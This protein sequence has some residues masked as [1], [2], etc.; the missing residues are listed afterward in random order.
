[1]EKDEGLQLK[2]EE[3]EILD[4][5]HSHLKLG[6]LQ[7]F[8]EINEIAQHLRDELDDLKRNEVERIRKLLKAENKM[9]QGKK[10]NFEVLINDVGQVQN[11]LLK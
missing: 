3:A 1:M 2:M 6:A 5:S 8:D 10:I 11:K 7:E 4:P 9:N